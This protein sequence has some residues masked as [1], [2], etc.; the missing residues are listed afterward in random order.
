MDD[1]QTYKQ[2]FAMKNHPASRQIPQNIKEGFE[3]ELVKFEHELVAAM[4]MQF[5]AGLVDIEAFDYSTKFT[6]LTEGPL[7]EQF[8]SIHWEIISSPIRQTP[9]LGLIYVDYK[10]V[11]PSIYCCHRITLLSDQYAIMHK[12]GK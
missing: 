11:S 7:L 5:E 4:Q 8:W 3:R 10:L 6:V 12:L 1:A 9:V 2:V